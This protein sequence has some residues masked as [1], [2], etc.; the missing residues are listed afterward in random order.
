MSVDTS[1]SNI[2]RI[3]FINLRRFGREL[4]LARFGY[5][6]YSVEKS[7]YNLR[8]W[9]GISKKNYCWDL[10]SVT[11]KSEVYDALEDEEAWESAEAVQV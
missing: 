5:D 4:R 1:T 3:T 9:E 6:G 7:V 11:E 2:E 10:L 8:I